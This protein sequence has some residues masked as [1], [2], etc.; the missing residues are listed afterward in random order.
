WCCP[1]RNRG[2][3]GP[4]GQLLPQGVEENAASGMAKRRICASQRTVALKILA[5]WACCRHRRR[6]WSQIAS[7]D[8]WAEAKNRRAVCPCLAAWR[9]GPEERVGH[10]YRRPSSL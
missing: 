4:P 1:R 9:E 5:T 8:Q 3:H 2:Q 6:T 10:Q 7:G